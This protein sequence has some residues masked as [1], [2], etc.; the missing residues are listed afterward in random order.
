MWG[1]KGVFDNPFVAN[2]FQAGMPAAPSVQG[3]L[4]FGPSGK[5]GAALGIDQCVPVHS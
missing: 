5:P 3:P 2:P 1:S 4:S